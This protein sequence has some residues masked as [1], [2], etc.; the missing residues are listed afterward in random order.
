MDQEV[1]FHP[2]A[3]MFPLLDGDEFEELVADIKK[4]GLLQKIERL[5]DGTIIDGRNRYRACLEA[6][7]E[8]KYET[9]TPNRTAVQEYVVSTN[10][11]RRHLTASQRAALAL[12]LMPKLKEEAH[13]RM[14]DGGGD[15][16]PEAGSER[17]PDPVA[18][19][20]EAREKAAKLLRVNP[21]Y[22]SD[23][24]TIRREDPEAIA[25]IKAGKTTIPKAKKKLAKK[26][27]TSTQS[28]TAKR[29][30]AQ[31]AIQEE[32]R[33]FLFSV[34]SLSGNA[35]SVSDCI[36]R[37]KSACKPDELL[38][39]AKSLQDS[40][41]LL[42]DASERLKVII[43]SDPTRFGTVA[44]AAT[45][46]ADPTPEA[47]ATDTADVSGDAE[48]PGRSSVPRWRTRSRAGH[49]LRRTRRDFSRGEHRIS[50]NNGIERT[51]TIEH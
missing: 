25:D 26:K 36:D 37:A 32:R 8:P 30:A 16:R 20:G 13:Q 29:K 17:I 23:I 51:P 28:A 3:E 35:T 34:N 14:V 9:W 31:E 44:P 21:H 40:I 47:P 43:E 15:H 4:N 5:E 2:A 22:I 33:Q 49:E 27:K 39:A 1:K 41:A 6:G 45:A 18:E 12:E 38:S 11:Y 46:P 48:T 10:I 42:T 19:T 50:R 7:V 24:E